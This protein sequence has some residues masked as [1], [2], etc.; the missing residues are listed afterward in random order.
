MNNKKTF[1]IVGIIILLLIVISGGVWFFLSKEPAQNQTQNTNPFGESGNENSNV[2]IT[3]N[4]ENPSGESFASTPFTPTERLNRIS[5]SPISGATF[6]PQGSSTIVRYIEKATGHIYDINLSDGTRNR[7]TNTTNPK[8]SEVAWKN[9]SS[10]VLSFDEQNVIKSILGTISS[11]TSSTTQAEKELLT[12]DL[13]SNPINV[14][15]SP[16]KKTVFYTLVNSLGIEGF[17]SDTSFQ[18]S[19]LVWEF[20]TSE[21]IVS[22]PKDDILTLTTKASSGKNGSLYFLNPINKKF[23]KIIGGIPGLTT[24]TSPAGSLILYSSS[25]NDQTSLY[26]Y[27]VSS[28]ISLDVGIVSLPEKCIWS[29]AIIY[30]AVSKNGLGSDVPEKWYQGIASYTDTLWKINLGGAEGLEESEYFDIS[31]SAGGPIDLINPQLS[32]DKKILIFTNKRDSYLWAL[33]IE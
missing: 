13:L 26:L 16:S 6:Y 19:T 28:H 31:K 11:S 24:N 30:C 10:F 20:P 1:I 17:L 3:G 8:V 18:K 14:V 2:P 15:F 23:T 33:T 5:T 21:W 22:W 4:S 25:I 12:K 32:D 27:D 9:E 29:D 7:I